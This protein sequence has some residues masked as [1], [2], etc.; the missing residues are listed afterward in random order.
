MNN[1]PYK[2][3]ELTHTLNENTPSWDGGCG[4]KSEVKL[5]YMD[6]NN[7]V[8]FRVQQIKMHAGIGTHIDAPAHVV[9]GGAT[10]ENIALDNLVRP[11]VCIDVSKDIQADFKLSSNDILA[12]EKKHGEIND[13]NFF[14]V[15]TGWD[16]HWVSPEKYHNKYQFPSISPDAALLLLERNIAGI[17][18]D[19]LSPD[20][21]SSGF[22][23]HKHILGAGKYIVENVANAS[24][25]PAVG[26]FALVMPIK[27]AGLTEAPVRLIGLVKC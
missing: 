7:E 15:Y 17:G 23:V 3:I 9:P 16:K 22:P 25:L 24:L 19:T 4:F 13:G 5:D 27:I 8:K 12:F 21:P 6:C 2:I 18:I 14:I 26:S 1:F 11:C 20:V 10:V